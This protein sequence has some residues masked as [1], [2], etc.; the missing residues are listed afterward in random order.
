MILEISQRGRKVLLD[1]AHVLSDIPASPKVAPNNQQPSSQ[2]FANV[3]NDFWFHVAWTAKKLRRGELWI[4][5]KC[6]DT[7]LKSLLLRMIE[8]EAQSV[9]DWKTDTWFDGR[10]LEQWAIPYT[11]EELHQAFA[12]YDPEDVW[13]A[14][15]AT[16][17]AFQ[18]IA[19]NVSIQLG[20]IYPSEDAEQICAWVDRIHTT[21]A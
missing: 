14:L 21:G 11:V 12:Y 2:L 13:R 18:R 16:S 10:F 20:Y 17:R 1:K 19:K 6:C 7:H 4:A 5:K 9:N 8:W 3:V 15:N